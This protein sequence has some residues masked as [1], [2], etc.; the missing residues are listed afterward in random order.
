[1]SPLAAAAPIAFAFASLSPNARSRS[2]SGA[3]AKAQNA[4]C[5]Q[6]K[7]NEAAHDRGHGSVP[8]GIDKVNGGSE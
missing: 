4:D 5:T 3:N 6:D 2:V 1:M 8:G 7:R